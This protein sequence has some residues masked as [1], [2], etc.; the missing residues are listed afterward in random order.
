MTQVLLKAAFGFAGVSGC[1][2]HVG[3]VGSICELERKRAADWPT[4][5][6]LCAASVSHELVPCLL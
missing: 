4:V 5:S 1:L 2:G 6:F 3:T